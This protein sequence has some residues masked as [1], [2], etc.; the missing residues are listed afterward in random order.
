[1]AFVVPGD[2]KWCLRKLR[3]Y[4]YKVT[5]GDGWTGSGF[6]KIV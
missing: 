1:M 3:L 4:G 5:G 6:I 2:F